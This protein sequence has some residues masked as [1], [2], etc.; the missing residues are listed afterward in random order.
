MARLFRVQPALYIALILFREGIAVVLAVTQNKYLPLREVG[1]YVHA[2]FF[3]L[4]KYLQLFHFLHVFLAYLG[5]A[6]MGAE[7]CIAKAFE[8]RVVLIESLMQKK[9]PRSC[10]QAD[11]SA[12]RSGNKAPPA[13]PSK[14]V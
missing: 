13:R 4:A 12:R 2:R 3:R 11:I 6:R 10:F 1:D 14:C 9:R 7:K 8:Q 5:M